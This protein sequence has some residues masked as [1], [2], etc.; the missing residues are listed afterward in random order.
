MAENSKKSPQTPPGF[1]RGEVQETRNSKRGTY[2]GYT[3]E[4]KGQIAIEPPLNAE[5]IEFLTNFNNTRRMNRK[6]GPYFV[7]GYGLRGQGH[8]DDVIDYNGPPHGQPGLW[9]Q[10]TPT[11]DGRFIQWDGGEKFYHAAAWMRYIIDHFISPDHIA[12]MPF[13]QGHICSGS[14]LAKGEDI[15]DR[16]R[17]E[18]IDNDVKVIHLP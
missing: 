10:W 18:V 4:F 15:N 9:C 3:T 6:R 1:S 13:F 2:M 16:W 11:P 8:D 12:D 17:L 7:D 14:I 5:E